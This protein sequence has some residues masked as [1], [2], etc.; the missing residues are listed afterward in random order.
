MRFGEYLIEFSPQTPYKVKWSLRLSWNPPGQENCL[1]LEK[2][3]SIFGQL[4]IRSSVDQKLSA[5]SLYSGSLVLLWTSFILLH[6]TAQPI[7]YLQ[8]S[9]LFPAA[10]FIPNESQSPSLCYLFMFM[11]KWSA[12]G[13]TCT[14]GTRSFLWFPG[15]LR[16]AIQGNLTWGDRIHHALGLT[17]E[18]GVSSGL[19]ER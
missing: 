18:S 9:T 17:L 14:D 6:L 2:D 11:I 16:D 3:W 15:M 10:S 7:K 19:G 8:V 4:Q 13:V 1:P 5:G 12:P